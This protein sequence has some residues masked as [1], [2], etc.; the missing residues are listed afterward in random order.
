MLMKN[1]KSILGIIVLVAII[2][3]S[4]LINLYTDW[5]WFSSIGYLGVF[6]K[7][8]F[9]KVALFVVGGV[10]VFGLVYLNLW[11]SRK[12]L[13]KT[14]LDNVL[15]LGALGVGALG[16]LSLVGSWNRVLLFLNQS[17][18]GVVDPIFGKDVGF[19][20][21]T[22]PIL[23]LIK[24]FLLL[25]IVFS[26]G[27]VFAKLVISLG[28]KDM[29]EV[30]NN[31]PT[32]FASHLSGLFAIIFGLVGFHFYLNR[33]SVLYSDLGVVYGAGH[34]D[35][36]VVLP[37][38]WIMMILSVIIALVFVY[39]IWN[40]SFRV[41]P[42]LVLLI[43][44]VGVLG[45]SLAPSVFQGLRVS[46]NELDLEEKYIENNI[47]FT[48]KAYDLEKVETRDFE[49][50]TNISIGE[51]E[52]NSRTIENAR[53][54]DY[55]ALQ[56][57]YEQ[58]QEI[59]LYY[60][61]TD[62]DID[63]YSLN[64]SDGYRQV[65]LSTREI[66]VD[67]L[68]SQ[69]DTW[70]NNHLIY[71]HGYGA[72]MSPVNKKTSEGAP[73]FLVKDI[74]PE[75]EVK[76]TRPE[77]YYGTLDYSYAI[78]DTDRKE[79]DY[80]SG[81]ENVY[82]SY[83]G[84]GGVELSGLRELAYSYSFGSINMFL[85]DY[86]NEDSQLMIHRNVKERV[87]T[88]AP[89]LELDKDPYVVLEDGRIHWIIDAYTTT[90]DYPYSQ[91]SGGQNYVRNSVKVVV[92]AY[93][94]DVSFYVA[95]EDDPIINSWKNVFPN[96]FESLEEMPNNLRDHIRYP[97]D[98]FSLQ[99]EVYREYH[100]QEAEVF[101]NQEDMWEIPQE[102]Y[103]NQ[104]QR[105][106]PYYVSISLPNTNKTE[107]M[108]IQPFTPS[109]RDNMIGWVGARSDSPNYGELLN[110]RFPKGKLIYG[111]SQIE[112]RIDQDPTISQQLTLWDQRGSQLIR[113][114]LLAIPLDD[115]MLYIE[116]VFIQSDEGSIPELR[117]VIVSNGDNVVMAET[118]DKGIDRLVGER[119]EDGGIGD[120]ESSIQ[121][122]LQNYYNALKAQQQGNWSQYGE[123]MDELEE[124][125][126]DLN[127]T[128]TQPPE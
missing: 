72:V 27:F 76:I 54:W 39:N 22:L 111:P 124:S 13:G 28:A 114:N 92:D 109:N 68:S 51:I 3:S 115:S 89:F 75:G 24:N 77:V 126:E 42:L 67:K 116:P 99:M 11:F 19:Y 108:L 25:G 53:L 91:P 10:F 9:T 119:A 23:G 15:I 80:P 18:F 93:N 102:K 32:R 45:G 20:V 1:K 7:T 98:Y 103:S 29:E 83:K 31:L 81:D 48:R 14:E 104:R 49:A 79:F 100:M 38:I 101:Y 43:L 112:A 69:A 41:I 125:L 84:S 55:R 35:V 46:P 44:V 120:I 73:T 128:T 47:E 105:V 33:F 87:E 16:G 57:T 4:S 26:L 17:S 62:V 61:F 40:R 95:D 34:T 85:T 88:I 5:V 66:D 63:R 52:N 6:S 122:A 70:V 117:R 71:T 50:N 21:F 127:S 106:E 2:A 97:E 37:V 74:P 118:L 58:L 56:T 123:H 110:Y 60:T 107:F 36:N 82:T 90:N 113:G 12:Y 8:L 64:E 94:G 78:T 65:M 121:Q 96:M 59:R 30:L 86:T